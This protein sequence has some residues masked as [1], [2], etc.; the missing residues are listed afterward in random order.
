MGRLN[1]L[2]HQT[3]H[4]ASCFCFDWPRTI[5]LHAI[6]RPSED[7]SFE[8]VENKGMEDRD[9]ILR[10]LP[11]NTIANLRGSVLSVLMV[12]PYY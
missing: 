9:S 12:Y 7:D 10:S 3:H 6:R 1:N 2:R 4:I 5:W 11:K 8:H